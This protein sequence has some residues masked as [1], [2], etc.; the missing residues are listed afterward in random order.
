MNSYIL[1]N[2]DKTEKEKKKVGSMTI[3]LDMSKVY[4]KVEWDFL[5]AMMLKLA[6]GEKWTGLIMTCVKS[7]T[8]FVKVNGVPSNTIF[9]SRGLRQC[10][11]LSPYLFIL[12]GER[13]SS[14]FQQAERNGLI[15]GVA[16]SRGDLTINHL[17]F[18]YDHVIFCRAK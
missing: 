18:A 17:L 7:V 15:K 6:F 4:D 13:L 12:C 10:D 16:A 1:C 11:P 2:L 3:K 9:P 5:E 8:Y 14:L